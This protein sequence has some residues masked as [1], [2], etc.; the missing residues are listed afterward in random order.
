MSATV[1]PVRDEAETVSPPRNRMAIALLSLVGFFIAVYM[2]L[3]KLGVIGTLACG[4]GGSCDTVQS[5]SWAIFLGVPVP[6]WG[7][8]GYGAIFVASLAGLQTRGRADLWV[9]RSLL[10]LATG[11]FVFSAYLAALEAFVIHA[12]C[13][14]CIVSAVLATLIFLCSLAEIGRLGSGSDE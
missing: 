5:S 8:V 4:A 11:A 7:V 13:R 3:Y 10:G 2:L 9:A 6:A 12:W 1:T 14:W